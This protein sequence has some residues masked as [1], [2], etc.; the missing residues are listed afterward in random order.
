MNVK[1]IAKAAARAYLERFPKDRH[2]KHETIND[3]FHRLKETGS[4]TPRPR[5]NRRAKCNVRA[6]LEE[7]L[8]F[9]LLNSQL[10]T[11]EIN[12]TCGYMHQLA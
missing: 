4:I 7:V 11:A 2:T 9:T 12:E 5:Q 6:T 10:N 8:V 3:V 1:K